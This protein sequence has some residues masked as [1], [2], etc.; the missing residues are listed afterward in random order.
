MKAFFFVVDEN[1]ADVAS[2]QALNLI[3]LTGCDVHIF[4]ERL[5][6]RAIVS[7]LLTVFSLKYHYDVLGDMLPPNLPFSEKWPPIV[8][9]RVFAPFFLQEYNRVL[10]LD[11]DVHCRHF[12]D[13]IWSV[14]LPNGLAAVHDL[15]IAVSEPLGLTIDKREWLD[16]IGVSDARYF[17]SGVLLIDVRKW[18][19]VDFERKLVDYFE[20]YG[21]KVYMFDQDFLNYLFQGKWV[22]L[23]P[24]WN[25]QAALFP[26]GYEDFFEPIF[27]HYSQYDKPW[28]GFYGYDEE[29]YLL[30]KSLFERANLDISVQHKRRPWSGPGPITRMK[31]NFRRHLS[32][33]GL[34]SRKEK[35]LR[36]R[37][38]IKRFKYGYFFIQAFE[39][40]LFSLEDRKEFKVG[41]PSLSFTGSKLILEH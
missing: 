19:D 21:S 17:N 41:E 27:Y 5:D 4:V 8:Y 18:C 2:A 30:Y 15:V 36:K 40:N 22:E 1:L 25:F 7:E 37:W 13:R 39:E 11:A 32:K 14:E 35:R 12:D 28:Y 26:Y 24:K 33:I 10:Y 20:T 29:G 23:S 38:T 16:S 34:M 6:K 9:L 31:R 3:Q